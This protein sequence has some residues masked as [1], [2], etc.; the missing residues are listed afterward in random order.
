MMDEQEITKHQRQRSCPEKMV[1]FRLGVDKYAKLEE[2]RSAQGLRSVSDLIRQAIESLIHDAPL[3]ASSNDN[4]SLRVG[5]L[6]RKV[7]SLAR[8]LRT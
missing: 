8:R 7:D 2:V 1:S 4:L 5:R 3:K 6:E